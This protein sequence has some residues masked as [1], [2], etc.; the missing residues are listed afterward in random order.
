[1]EGLTPGR[2]VHY[3][4]DEDHLHNPAVVVRVDAKRGRVDLQVFNTVIDGTRLL[5]DIDYSE[6]PVV[7]SWH[8]IEKA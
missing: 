5:L 8:W 1:M 3:A 4:V 6:E 7:G 2:M